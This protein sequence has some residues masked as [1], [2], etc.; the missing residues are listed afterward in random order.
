MISR[1]STSRNDALLR[2][3]GDLEEL[4][5]SGGAEDL[6]AAVESAAVEWLRLLPLLL[7]PPAW[8]PASEHIG[9]GLLQASSKP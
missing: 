3:T 1:M 9:A 2:H 7:A 8:L 6:A 4:S 5:R